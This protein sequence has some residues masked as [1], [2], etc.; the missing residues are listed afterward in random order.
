MEKQVNEWVD[1]EEIE[2]KHV[3]HT[4]GILQGKTNEENIFVTVWY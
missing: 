3:G 4:I 1:G 2:V